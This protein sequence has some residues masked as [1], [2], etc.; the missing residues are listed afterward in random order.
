M[1]TSLEHAKRNGAKMIA[2]NPLAEG[3]LM[4]VKNPNP[5]EYRNPLG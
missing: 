4:R 1:M 3:R 2:I 5:Q